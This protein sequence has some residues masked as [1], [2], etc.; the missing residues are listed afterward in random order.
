MAAQGTHNPEYD[1][2]VEFEGK[3]A[4]EA[5]LAAYESAGVDHMSAET[6]LDDA[7]DPDALNRLFA[8]RRAP[9]TALLS[10]DLWGKR[11]LVGGGEVRLYDR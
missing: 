6:T 8:E 9:D 5:V 4:V 10:V 3:T 11:A 2:R 1:I 7:I